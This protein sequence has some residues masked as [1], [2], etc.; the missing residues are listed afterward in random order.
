MGWWQAS[1]EFYDS[2]VLGLGEG[3]V[4]VIGWAL[5]MASR[6]WMGHVVGYRV[7]PC[8]HTLQLEKKDHRQLSVK[9]NSH[10]RVHILSIWGDYFSFY[11]SS[12]HAINLRNFTY[13]VLLIKK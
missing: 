10:M 3:L 2:V 11:Y 9:R 12:L 4:V 6:A 13:V 1:L 8:T 5:L 7:S